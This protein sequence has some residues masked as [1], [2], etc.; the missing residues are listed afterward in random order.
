MFKPTTKKKSV[1]NIVP[2]ID[3]I[4][5]LLAFFMLFTTFKVTPEGL[6]LQLPTAVTVQ[7]QEQENLVI[8]INETGQIYLQ[9]RQMSLSEMK[10]I[11]IEE[12]EVNKDIIVVINGD[13]KVDYEHVVAIMD[14][15]REI[16]ISNLALAAQREES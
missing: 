6:D 14:N 15:L 3:V 10:N 12:Y 1:I 2:M 8:N 16:G 5:V 11:I 13:K 7:E 9:D 4:F